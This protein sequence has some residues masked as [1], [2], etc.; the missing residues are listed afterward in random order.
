[1]TGDPAKFGWHCWNIGAT[2]P[3]L[4][5][6]PQLTSLHRCHLP[7]CPYHRVASIRQP[8]GNS[9]CQ[10]ELR[11]NHSPL[12]PIPSTLTCLPHIHPP[13]IQGSLYSIH[14]PKPRPPSTTSPINFCIHYLFQQS[15]II[16]PLYMTEPSQNI[17]IYSSCQFSPHT[18]SR[19]HYFIPN[20][21][22]PRYTSYSSDISSQ[23]HLVYVSQLLSYH[24]TLSH[25]L[26]LAQPLSHTK[27]S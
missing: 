8:R 5:R 27:L 22:Q 2:Q 6:L 23:T 17:H 24:M 13:I 25:T 26:Q 11:H 21:I 15:F 14:P 3:V 20:P 10:S 18:F 19:S 4:P 7:Y 1:M 9:R 12:I 16:H